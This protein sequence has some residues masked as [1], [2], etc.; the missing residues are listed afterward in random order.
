MNLSIQYRCTTRHH[1]A[2]VVLNRAWQIF[3][4]HKQTKFLY[5]EFGWMMIYERDFLGACA[6]MEECF[7]KRSI[8]PFEMLFF[9]ESAWITGT[10]KKY[11]DHI[12]SNVIYNQQFNCSYFLCAFLLSKYAS[13]DAVKRMMNIIDQKI[14]IEIKEFEDEFKL[15]E[16]GL[17]PPADKSIEKFVILGIDNIVT[18]GR[19]EKEIIELEM[20]ENN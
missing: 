16:Y 1:D 4:K 3:R 6:Y 9:T 12:L 8:Q 7:L 18:G 5:A 17:R 20:H 14:L 19:H 11:A 13:E 15:S 10:I 2:F